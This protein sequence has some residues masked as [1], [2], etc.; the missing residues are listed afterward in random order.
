MIS[1]I[2]CA[3]IWYAIAVIGIRAI[4]TS[5]N[6]SGNNPVMN[7]VCKDNSLQSSFDVSNKDAA[8]VF[9]I[10]FLFRVIVFAISFRINRLENR[11]YTFRL[12]FLL[13]QYH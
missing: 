13:E 6:F 10:A 3:L 2:L 5:G 9:G 12:K 4:T 8:K 7:F 11:L 1:T